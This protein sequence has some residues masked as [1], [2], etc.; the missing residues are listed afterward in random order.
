MLHPCTPHT[1]PSPKH[2]SG[3]ALVP[4][5]ICG[6]RHKAKKEGAPA[7]GPPSYPLLLVCVGRR[8]CGTGTG[9]IS[10]T[11]LRGRFAGRRLS[12]EQ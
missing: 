5:G 3:E 9:N 6:V 4:T 7:G 12:R 11:G 2:N 10:P 8:A 1:V